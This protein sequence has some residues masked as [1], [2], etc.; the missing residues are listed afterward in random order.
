VSVVLFV[1][2][3]FFSRT[4]LADWSN[5]P[6]QVIVGC[7]VL[8]PSGTI[9]RQFPGSLCQYLDD[10][11][12]VSATDKAVRR[13]NVKGEVIWEVVGHFHHQMNLSVDKTRVLI[14]SSTPFAKNPKW[15]EDKLMVLSIFDGKELAATSITRF[16]PGTSLFFPPWPAPP[17]TPS[18]EGEVSH[19][20]SI[21]EVPELEKNYRG[22]LKKG[23]IVVNSLGL[24]ILVLSSDLQTKKMHF[25]HGGSFQHTVHD[26]QPLPSGKLLLFNNRGSFSSLHSRVDRLDPVTLKSEVLFK[27]DPPEAFYSMRGGGVQLYREDYLVISPFHTGTLIYD[28]RTKKVVASYSQTYADNQRVWTI[29]QARLENITA[30]LSHYRVK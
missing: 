26:V 23:D 6:F 21:Y 14:L 1:L 11:S 7:K 15:R 10:G 2:S 20:N 28:L 8:N 25:H 9:L 19:A 24:G 5:R 29:Q 17:A 4:V 27:A 3:F 16:V 18:F 30:F 13:I 12:F 22:P